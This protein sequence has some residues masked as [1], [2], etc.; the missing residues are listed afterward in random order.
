MLKNF[1]IFLLFITHIL[2]ISN[3]PVKASDQQVK[4]ACAVD[5]FKQQLRLGVETQMG[6]IELQGKFNN[7]VKCTV[8]FGLNQNCREYYFEKFNNM[9]AMLQVRQV[10]K[11]GS[12]YYM[13]SQLGFSTYYVTYILDNAGR[14]SI[15]LITNGREVLNDSYS[16]ITE[17][18]IIRLYKENYQKVCALSEMNDQQFEKAFRDMGGLL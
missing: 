2:L 10:P 16:G 4:A 3:T 8:Q 18:E 1:P 5:T 15:D 13:F 12:E 9:Q 17:D 11:K 6:N 14:F 7:R